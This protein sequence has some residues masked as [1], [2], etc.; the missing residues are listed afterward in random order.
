MSI[1]DNTRQF[2]D[3]A[4]RVVA[5]FETTEVERRRSS[6]SSSCSR[7]TARFRSPVRGADLGEFQHA[8]VGQFDLARV[9]ARETD[10]LE[11][12][13]NGNNQSGRQRHRNVLY[14]RL[15]QDRTGC[16]RSNIAR[17]TRSDCVP[18]EAI[19]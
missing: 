3:E 16:A 1:P 18:G 14:R 12:H 4:W 5:V 2:E 8:L 15:G 17:P 19:G 13:E 7:K 6:A 9:T 10:L 11:G